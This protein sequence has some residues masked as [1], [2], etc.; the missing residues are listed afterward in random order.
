MGTILLI[1]GTGKDPETGKVVFNAFAV[2]SYDDVKKEYRI[3]GEWSETA[4]A[5]VGDR[6]EF[7]SVR[8]LL[9]RMAD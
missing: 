5:K 4:T 2:V 1:E 9:K 3:K 7:T 8:M 6:P